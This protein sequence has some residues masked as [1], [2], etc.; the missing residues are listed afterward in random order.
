VT[1]LGRSGGRR[2]VRLAGW[3]R[4]A[5]VRSGW[6]LATGVLVAG[7]AS[8]PG[9]RGALLRPTQAPSASAA[10]SRPAVTAVPTV[11]PVPSATGAPSPTGFGE[12]VAVPCAG[13]PDADQ[14]LALLRHQGLANAG[15]TVAQGPLCA[16][17]WQY[18][19]VVQS[20]HEPL[21]VVTRGAPGSLR[22]VTAGTYVCSV[23]VRAGAPAGILTLARCA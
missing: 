2:R 9:D 22:L 19:V 8:G 7:C 14:V 10:P 20:G 4:P 6:V 23:D 13:R 11:P 1:G 15:A 21:Q 16:G 3:L 17:T 5:L 18:S 12:A